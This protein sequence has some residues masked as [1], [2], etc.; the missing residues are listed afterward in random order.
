ME[1]LNLGIGSKVE[2][3][4]DEEGFR[5]AWYVATVL[6]PPTLSPS[7]K[8]FVE[9][10]SLLANENGSDLLREF[11]D[12]KFVRPLPPVVSGLVQFK[13]DDRV[14][15]YYQ[16]G[17][18]SGV[19]TQ[20]VHPHSLYKVFFSNPPDELLF[21]SSDLRIHRT[22]FNGVW[23]LPPQPNPQTMRDFKFSPGTS[24]EVNLDVHNSH[25]VWFPA[26]VVNQVCST[27]F[28]V[29][30]HTPTMP[31]LQKVGIDSL[32]IRPPPPIT[33]TKAFT[34]LEK[35][36]AFCDSCWLTGIVTKI[37]GAGRYIVYFKHTRK[38]KELCLTDLR[39]HMEWTNGKWLHSSQDTSIAS[40]SEKQSVCLNGGNPNNKCAVNEE[41]VVMKESNG[42]VRISVMRLSEKDSQTTGSGRADYIGITPANERNKQTN[43]NGDAISARRSRRSTEEAVSDA[44]LSPRTC[45]PNINQTEVLNTG[46]SLAF[47]SS[48]P[49]HQTKSSSKQSDDASQPSDLTDIEGGYEKPSVA[50][51]RENPPKLRA[52]VAGDIQLEAHAETAIESLTRSDSLEPIAPPEPIVID[53]THNSSGPLLKQRTILHRKQ[54]DAS[55]NLETLGEP[56]KAGEVINVKR[57]RGRPPKALSQL[58]SPKTIEAVSVEKVRQDVCVEGSSVTPS[59]T[60]QVENPVAINKL[61][62]INTSAPSGPPEKVARMI[63]DIPKQVGLKTSK[64]STAR[65]RAEKYRKIST[66]ATIEPDNTL[67]LRG[68]KL[69]SINQAELATED[70][71]RGEAVEEAENEVGGEDN[72]AAGVTLSN[73]IEDDQPLSAWLDGQHSPATD[74]RGSTD[75]VAGQFGETEYEAPQ[76]GQS[77]ENGPEE[78]DETSGEQPR[79]DDDSSETRD[80]TS[81]IVVGVKDEEL[82]FIKNSVIWEMIESMEILKVVP[83]KPH[84]RPLYKCKEECREGLAI[85]KMVTFTS[86]AEKISRAHFE[87]PERMLEGYHEALVELEEHGFEIVGVRERLEK[88]ISIKKR[89]EE[90]E[91]RREEIERQIREREEE[92][93]KI[94]EEIE[95]VEKEMA[96]VK[97]KQ[98]RMEW[99]KEKKEGEMRVME[100]S[101]EAVKG[102]LASA[103]QKFDKLAASLL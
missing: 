60:D 44:I 92:R 1:E 5:G 86:I 77:K 25:D 61:L 101:V 31:G 3:S 9:Y 47:D 8:I 22:W 6:K 55:S 93:S 16:D 35:V 45:N 46:T 10:D 41:S 34:L 87:D 17:W 26:K 84:F 57:K 56:H 33:T 75:R 82:P 66:E 29:E 70:N 103:Q 54:L 95:K 7:T 50:T 74:E 73:A 48:M 99:S 15:A 91:K 13:P 97:E 102:V 89:H 20:V 53:F 96:E 63:S 59:R 32:H 64:R 90:D 11:I 21:N 37:L 4:S 65:R 39:L 83:Q 58:D 100:A 40:K 30:C 94:E 69:K 12:L 71:S 76:G 81:T 62:Q 68:K 28:L 51:K 18:W 19:V 38:E 49:D 36:D 78:I 43:A 88:L 79:R 42:H 14:D 52:Q 27:M 67:I 2:V 98:R 85:G 23:C 24:V 72:T 80:E